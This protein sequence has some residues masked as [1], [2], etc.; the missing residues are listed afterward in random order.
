M[1]RVVQMNRMLKTGKSGS[2]GNHGLKVRGKLPT[3][4]NDD[5][6]DDGTISAFYS[7][8]K[9][10]IGWVECRSHRMCFPVLLFVF[11]W[12]HVAGGQC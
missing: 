12:N 6:D 2:G 8:K 5:K 4:R 1:I 9:E 10:Y 7:Q 3:Q 11:Y